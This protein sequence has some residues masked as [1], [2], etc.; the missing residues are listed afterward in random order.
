MRFQNTLVYFLI[1]S[2][3]IFFHIK[4]GSSKTDKPIVGKTFLLTVERGAFHNDCF[5]ITP[6]KLSY[7][8]KKDAQFK[9]EKY[10]SYSEVALDSTATKKIL[11]H[12][13]VEG[14]W[15]LKHAYIDNS[16]DTSQLKITLT[17]NGKTKSVICDDFERSCPELLK[18]IEKK[19]I[20]LEGN[21]LK[22]IY[23]PG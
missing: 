10:N 8:P 14:F 15:N 3:A 19:V 1:L 4:N 11:A 18:F 20:E 5:E 23:L 22:R 13:E 17:V 16:S 2:V 7:Q 6:T 12:I 21:D 9:L